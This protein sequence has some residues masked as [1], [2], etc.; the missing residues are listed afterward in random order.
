MPHF[1]GNVTDDVRI[2]IA[3]G[4][5]SGRGFAI[6]EGQLVRVGRGAK[7]E[8]S[9]PED[10]RLSTLHFSIE[11]QGT[12]WEIQDL[13]STLGTFVNG[14]S[15]GR[16]L[17]TDGD[18]IR[19]GQCVFIFHAALE[20]PNQPF[21]LSKD[22]REILFEDA[23]PVYAL[24]DA[25]RD[26]RVLR[27]LEDSGEPHHS[28]YEGKQGEDL[29]DYA[30]YLVRV[31]EDSPLVQELLEHAWGRNW[32]DFLRC[33][34]SSL[35]VRRHFR[36]FLLVRDESGEEFYFRFY[37]PR[38]LRV[39]LPSCTPEQRLEF[40]GPVR[41]F[42]LESECG[43]RLLNFLPSGSCIEQKICSPMIAPLLERD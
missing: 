23:Q 6:P 10:R 7:A 8:V 1:V 32:G 37:D 9:I 11:R 5:A 42:L 25:A 14:K 27:V 24:L 15:V 34:L 12:S 43:S 36:H 3:G 22:L 28:L 31:Y 30:P 29:A 13:D 39:F 40:F 18:E 16:A 33:E 20:A 17:L 26:R 21:V 2:E 19:A 41:C 4:P 38:V 35:E